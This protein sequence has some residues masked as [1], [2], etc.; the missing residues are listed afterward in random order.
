MLNE[1]TKDDI[2]SIKTM[3]TQHGSSVGHIFNR[4]NMLYFGMSTPYYGVLVK[5]KQHIDRPFSYM[6]NSQNFIKS[7]CKNRHTFNGVEI[8]IDYLKIVKQDYVL[9]LMPCQYPIIPDSGGR[10]YRVN[11]I[12]DGRIIFDEGEGFVPPYQFRNQYTL[13]FVNSMLPFIYS[14]DSRYII[15]DNGRIIF[16]ERTFIQQT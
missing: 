2:W 8:Y 6:F 4:N 5:Q 9:D 13:R 12:F 15:V 11:Q 3:M 16:W 7:V 10:K 1:T 14:N